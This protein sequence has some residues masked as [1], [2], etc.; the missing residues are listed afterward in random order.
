MYFNNA[1][2]SRE[3]GNSYQANNEINFIQRGKVVSIDDRDDAG[4]IKV[5]ILGVDNDKVD[6]EA[7]YAFPMLPKHINIVPN[8]KEG[9][10]IFT[11]KGTN[12]KYDRMYLGPMAPIRPRPM[13][14]LSSRLPCR[15]S[16]TC[17]PSC[18]NWRTPTGAA[19]SDP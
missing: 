6:S 2:F 16:P 13:R 14:R 18:W 12:N 4:R 5:R 11:F 1:K 19:A 3:G 8:V 9:V 15:L 10:L 17:L 7:F